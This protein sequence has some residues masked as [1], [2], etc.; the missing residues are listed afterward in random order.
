MIKIAR[1][2][3]YGLSLY[4]DIIFINEFTVLCAIGHNFKSLLCGM[5]EVCGR[6]PQPAASPSKTKVA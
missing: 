5:V 4:M 3:F 6:R 1:G 2:Y